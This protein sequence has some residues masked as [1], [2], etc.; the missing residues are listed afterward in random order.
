MM[1]VGI[2]WCLCILVMTAHYCMLRRSIKARL[3]KYIPQP[4]ARSTKAIVKPQY[5]GGRLGGFYRRTQ[6]LLH[7]KDKL[8]LMF[9]FCTIAFLVF[10]WLPPQKWYWQIGLALSCAI[11]LFGAVFS[12]RRRQQVEEFECGI[13]QVLGLVSRAVAAGLSVP[14]AIEQVA[15]TQDGI[16]GREFTLITDH[17]ALGMPLRQT[18]DQACIRLPYST[19]RYF[20]VALVLNQSNGGQLRDILH[21]LSRTMH[22]NRAM[23]KKVASITSEPRM[24]AKFLSLLPIFLI[25][26]IAWIDVSL[27]DLLIYSENGQWVVLYCFISLVLG[28]LSLHS[29]TKNRKFS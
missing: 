20:T 14:Q 27:F 6:A 9:S 4:R 17:L 21:N 24:T 12:L 15:N 3:V 16:L 7:R 10:W 23:R 18:L 25:A 8:M 19:F 22:D 5:S 26:A 11:G 2:V 29:L 28:G 13:V 1:M